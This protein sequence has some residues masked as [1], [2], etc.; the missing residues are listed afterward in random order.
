MS[1]QAFFSTRDQSTSAASLPVSDDYVPVS[2]TYSPTVPGYTP[3]SPTYSPTI[4]GYTPVSPTY[5]PSMP[6]YRPTSPTHPP[7]PRQSYTPVSPT[8]SPLGPDEPQRPASSR[9]RVRWERTLAE[10][11]EDA[12]QSVHECCEPFCKTY[13]AM[14]LIAK[15][16][17]HVANGTDNT[18]AG[19]HS[20]EM[21][22]DETR[23]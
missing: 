6:G 14:H 16:L 19:M 17:L 2:P 20:V 3:V 8:Y 1:T 22:R 12:M 4:P 13:R 21:M 23:V 5:S 11:C 18:S 9:K 10:E 15:V 7:P